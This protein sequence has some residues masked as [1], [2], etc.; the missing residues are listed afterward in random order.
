M[1][2]PSFTK[3]CVVEHQDDHVVIA[4]R[5][6]KSEIADNI[7]LLAALADLVPKDEHEP[8]RWNRESQK[9]VSQFE[10]ARQSQ[11]CRAVA[12][13][14]HDGSCVIDFSTAVPHV[15]PTDRSHRLSN[16]PKGVFAQCIIGPTMTDH[17]PTSQ[18]YRH[19]PA[20]VL[21]A[22]DGTP[23]LTLPALARAMRM[24]PKTVRRHREAQNL[25]AHNKGLGIKRQ[26]YVCTLND[27]AEFYRR[28]GEAA[29]ARGNGASQ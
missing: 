28:T 21:K 12:F 23:Y 13:E 19:V 11:D 9:S 1:I 22:F 3:H 27:V 8:R 6:P 18:S 25:P 15:M 24:D 16:A 2:F 20:E 26:H 4:I 14:H 29:S 7:H 17:L 10:Q 5:I